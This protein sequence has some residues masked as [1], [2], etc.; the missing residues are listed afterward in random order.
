MPGASEFQWL[1]LKNAQFIDG[2]PARPVVSAFTA[3]A[4]SKVRDDI[5]DKLKLNTP[6]IL[7]TGF[8]RKN[9]YF[10]VSKPK[11]KM[12]EL[13]Q[14]LRGR[15]NKFGI[16]YCS[17]RKTVDEVCDKLITSGFNAAKYHAGLTETERRENQDRFIYDD[18]NIMVAT[19]AFGMGID[20][21]NVSFVI[22]FNMPKNMESYY[23][24]AGRAGRDGA[25]A[26]CLLFYSGQDVITNQ[27]LIENSGG[28]EELNAE[29]IAAVRE[30]DRRLLKRM[31][32]Y[33][34]TNDCLREY[35]LNYFGERT[36][37]YCGHCS[38]CG[39]N[40]IE[41]DVTEEAK[42]VLCCIKECGERFGMKMLVDI[43]RGSKS[44][45]LISNR[46]NLLPA[47]GSMA[48]CPE[49]KIR[50]IL[51]FLFLQGFLEITDSEY[52]VVRLAKSSPKVIPEDFKVK[53]RVLKQYRQ[54]DEEEPEMDAGQSM[55]TG[56]A[57]PAGH[58][59]PYGQA[60][61]TK[62]SK[63]MKQARPSERSK[64]MDERLDAELFESL[65]L[66]RNRIAA[67][68]SVPAYIVFSDATLWD[69][70]RKMPVNRTDFMKV[71]G[72]GQAKL[73]RYGEL[74][75]DKIRSA[76]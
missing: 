74:F 69:M 10:A 7:T 29:E 64:D 67:E 39:S 54:Y 28:N 51:N 11:D 56:K 58:Y 41:A 46:L 2:L 66:L 45:R 1:Q 5:V 23:Q 52:P 25:P 3:T 43:L 4:T 24:E 60:N 75:I 35:I 22:H 15:E 21:S 38:N 18:A 27:F 76:K 14:Y 20:K 49:S 16:V 50:D 68:Q 62:R 6:Y 33:C 8:D 44:Q 63:N 42:K 17:T 34:H 13:K 55:H 19:N 12:A 26:E 70:C 48:G 53:M 57:K 65:R 59:E 36:S 40:F 61:Q 30:K 37:N 47:Y 31:T 73:E 9:L 72:V 32:F 71:T